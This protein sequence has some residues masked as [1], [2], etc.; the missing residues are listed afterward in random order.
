MK[1]IEIGKKNPRIP[2]S[3]LDQDACVMCNGLRPGNT[4]LCFAHLLKPFG[5][6]SGHGKGYTRV[7][8]PSGR[9]PSISLCC[10]F[11]KKK[12]SFTVLC[13]DFVFHERGP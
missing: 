10:P 1:T 6:R 7:V 4:P 9:L 5:T 2:N 3:H 11:L 8:H 12:L 13:S